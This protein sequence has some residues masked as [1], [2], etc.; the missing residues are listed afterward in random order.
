MIP[1]QKMY[2]DLLKSGKSLVDQIK[3]IVGNVPAAVRI[4]LIII[5][6]LL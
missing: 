2:I 6:T 5:L 1:N 4:E 3:L